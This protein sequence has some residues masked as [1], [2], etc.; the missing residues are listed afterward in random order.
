MTTRPRLH[1]CV[2]AIT[3]AEDKDGSLARDNGPSDRERNYS[4]L[5]IKQDFDRT[6]T[7]P[8]LDARSMSNRLHWGDD[9]SDCF[10]LLRCRSIPFS[11]EG[12]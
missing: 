2:G 12:A 6:A 4:R 7:T 3:R 8:Y 1:D 11:R 9:D 10:S 5:A